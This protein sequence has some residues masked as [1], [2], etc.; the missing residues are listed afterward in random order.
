MKKYTLQLSKQASKFLKKHHQE[1]NKF[2]KAF[3]EITKNYDQ[4]I[5]TYD[6]VAMVG[7]YESVYRLRIGKYRAKYK[8]HND[9]FI[10]FVMD[11][12]S[13]GSIYK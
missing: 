13:R 1:R 3:Q 8:L 5:S 2:I 9:V 10:L 7:Y 11:I 12:D 6:I 4:A